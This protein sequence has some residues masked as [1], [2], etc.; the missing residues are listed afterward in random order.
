MKVVLDSGILIRDFR[1]ES[2]SFQAFLSQH[3]NAGHQFIMLD[4]VRDEVLNKYQ[5]FL[6]QQKAD[7]DTGIHGIRLKTGR[8]IA[9]P[10]SNDDIT[11][12]C[13][14]YAALLNEKLE[15]FRATILEYPS[16]PHKKVVMRAL[17]RK[18]PFDPE[19]HKGYRDA[20]IWESILS[21]A[22]S[23]PVT[24][25]FVCLN[26]RDFADKNTRLLHQTLQEEIS[27]LNN[28]HGDVI[29]FPDLESFVSTEIEP[30]LQM[31]DE[32]IPEITGEGY[33]GF[34]LPNFTLNDLYEFIQYE[35]LE[36]RDI[37]L[38]RSFEELQISSIEDVNGIENVVIHPLF[39][40]N[41]LISYEASASVGF[42]FLI[43]HAAYFDISDE[44]LEKIEVWNS[45]WN[46][47]YRMCW[48]Q[49]DDIVMEIKLIFNKESATVQSAE[50]VNISLLNHRM[51]Y[52]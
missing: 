32:L 34:D 42:T 46:E 25:A 33:K 10:I 5:E 6:Q 3:A 1:M 15:T 23:E 13:N 14:D 31:V 11:Q 21:L 4:L 8:N 45:D 47:Y 7:I 50:L 52:Y 39:G 17:Q 9:T 30:Y 49:L 19:G 43:E 29:Y 24:I 35:T 22:A 38:P 40:S 28:E 41:L 44:L 2:P 26:P 27:N 48:V 51:G 37:D 12:M 16:I 18:K 20:L 36:P